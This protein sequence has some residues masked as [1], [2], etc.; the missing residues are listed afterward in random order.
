MT[1]NRRRIVALRGHQLA[2]SECVLLQIR[3]GDRNRRYLRT[4]RDKLGH[5]LQ[6]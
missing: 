2:I 6:L 1:N 3:P 4:K 5:L